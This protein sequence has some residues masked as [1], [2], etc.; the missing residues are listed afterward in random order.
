MATT[1]QKTAPR[2]TKK[3][4]N[5]K[6]LVVNPSRNSPDMINIHDRVPKQK[7]QGI[8]LKD[9]KGQKT[10]NPSKPVTARYLAQARGTIARNSN[11]ILR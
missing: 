3:S 9:R 10:P 8:P 6:G 1:S 7:G 11:K 2:S 4:K 5:P